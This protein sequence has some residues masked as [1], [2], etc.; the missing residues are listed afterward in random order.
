MGVY[1]FGYWAAHR[2]AMGGNAGAALGNPYMNA[3]TA[4][5]QQQ[6]MLHH[7]AMA[8]QVRA[9][10]AAEQQ[11]DSAAPRQEYDLELTAVDITGSDST[12]LVK[13]G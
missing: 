2:N 11:Q 6:A 8:H 3:A 7:L 10:K 13:A 5:M 1:D 4:G 9:R 12:D